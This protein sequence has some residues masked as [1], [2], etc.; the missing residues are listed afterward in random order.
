MIILL[1][2]IRHQ[3]KEM[4]ENIIKIYRHL[5]PGVYLLSVSAVPLPLSSPKECCHRDKA[6]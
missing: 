2:G 6:F 1:Q 3:C 5:E 4:F